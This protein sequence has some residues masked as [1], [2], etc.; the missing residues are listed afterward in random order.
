MYIDVC[1]HLNMC[2][3]WLSCVIGAVSVLTTH[4]ISVE[5]NGCAAMFRKS[6]VA[7]V[8]L[9][10]ALLCVTSFNYTMDYKLLVCA[11]SVPD[12]LFLDVV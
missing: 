11:V 3:S 12:C 8:D 6:I 9:M 7:R 5:L 1:T 2:I 4:N 10:T